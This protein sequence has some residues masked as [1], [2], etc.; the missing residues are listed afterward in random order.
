MVT[1][2][3]IVTSGALGALSTAALGGQLEVPMAAHGEQSGTDAAIAVVLSQIRQQLD[4]IGKTLDV[5]YRQNTLSH[6]NIP[7]I[8]EQFNYFARANFK[9]PD[10]CEVGLAVFYDLYDWHVKHGQ[11]LRLATYQNRMTI[12]FMFTQMILR[13]EQDPNYI[14]E[15]FDITRPG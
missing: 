2:R 3:E 10:Y 15:A 9:F 1:R 4:E 13:Y 6:G 12:R 7:K 5:A 11:E 14:S 8:R